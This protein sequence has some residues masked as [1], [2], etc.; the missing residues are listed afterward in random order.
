MIND[1]NRFA[2]F[3]GFGR[4]SQTG[5]SGADNNEIIW[6]ANA[7]NRHATPLFTKSDFQ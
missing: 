3:S 1:Q 7:V 5:G 2:V 6:F 4:G